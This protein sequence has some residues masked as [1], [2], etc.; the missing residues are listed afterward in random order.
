MGPG[1]A[2]RPRGLIHSQGSFSLFVAHSPISGM[3]H[4]LL[5]VGT[6]AVPGVFQ[7][8]KVPCVATNTLPAKRTGKA[9]STIF[10]KFLMAGSGL[11]FVLFV[12]GHMYGNLKL[13]WGEK[14]FNEYAHHLRTIGEPMLPHRGALIIFEVLLVLA[15]IAHVYSAFKLWGR[16]GAARSQ[17][18]AVKKTQVGGVSGHAKSAMRWGGVF[19]LLFVIFHL[20]QFT[21]PKVNFDGGSTENPYQLVHDSFELWW[22]ALIYVLAMIALALHLMHGIWSAA[23]T[24][25]YTSTPAA[26]LKAKAVAQIVAAVVVV[27]FLVPPLAI[28]FGII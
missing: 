16:A 23:Q 20:I 9:G 22:V 28:L 12:L 15:L 2:I 27:G 6:P 10:L 13:L 5:A 8:R 11:F 18:Y 7:G 19:L 14:S 25:G 26:R 1:G 4:N 24:L 3:G 17:R 21:L